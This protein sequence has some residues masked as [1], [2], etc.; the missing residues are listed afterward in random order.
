MTKDAKVWLGMTKDVKVIRL[1]MTK[2]AKVRIGM[3]K[4]AG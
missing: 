3:A 2:D 1:G 4:D